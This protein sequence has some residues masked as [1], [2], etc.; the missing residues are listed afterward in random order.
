MF[1]NLP[2]NQAGQAAR[3]TAPSSSQFLITPDNDND[4]PA[5]TR[6]VAFATAGAIKV[7]TANGETLIIP[8]GALA[9]GIVHPVRWTRVHSTGTTASG[10][11][12]FA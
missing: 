3:A 8:S 6:G 1:S 11:V 7:T 5:T 9:A 12:G 2:G 4:L 10:I